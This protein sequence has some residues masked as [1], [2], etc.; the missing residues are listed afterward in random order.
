MN[1]YFYDKIVKIKRL[2]TTSGNLRAYVATA[3][4]DASI[5]PL[6]KDRTQFREGVFGDQFTAYMSA[7][8]P[9]QVGDRLSEAGVIYTVTQVVQRDFGMD[10]YKELVIKKS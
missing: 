4:A 5:Q 6:G 1:E 10:P 7:D 3:T 2:K 8:V 9:V